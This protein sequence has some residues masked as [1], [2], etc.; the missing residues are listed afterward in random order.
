[1][2]RLET[3]FAFASMNARRGSTSS[4]IS[5]W[6]TSFGQHGVFHA[7]PQQ[8][9]PLGIHRRRPQLRRVHFAK[10]LVALQRDGAATL[11]VAEALHV[12]RRAPSR[13]R[14]R[15]RACPWRPGRAAAA[16]CRCSPPRSV[17]CICRKKN[18][19]SSVR[20]CAPSTSASV[21]MMILWY[22]AF[23]IVNS[24][25]MP[26]ADRGDDRPDFLVRQDLVDA[27]LLDVDD[28]A[29]ERQNGLEFA[30]ASLLGR[31]AGRVAL[32]EVELAQRRV[33]R[34]SSRR[35]CPAGCRRRAPTSCASGRAPCAPPRGRAP[36]TP[37]SR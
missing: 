5:V 16:R 23:S 9:A 18:V 28:L 19:R 35:A 24:S 33:D 8:R 14:R 3:N 25:L 11:A 17:R 4:P 13:R 32:D 7:H 31:T 27:R 2:S 21:M 22:R 15:T 37:P 26:V 36:P 1:M 12:T 20:M 6:K 34:A 30:V 10:S 29:A